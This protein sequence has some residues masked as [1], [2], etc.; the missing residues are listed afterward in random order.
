MFKSAFISGV[1]YFSWPEIFKFIHNMLC[2]DNGKVSN[3]CHLS[4]TI[5]KVRCP[6]ISLVSSFTPTILFHNP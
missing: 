1:Q 6:L 2:V 3:M 4:C 5:N